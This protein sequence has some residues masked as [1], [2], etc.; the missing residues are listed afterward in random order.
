MTEVEIAPQRNRGWGRLLVVTAALFVGLAGFTTAYAL[1]GNSDDDHVPDPSEGAV[2]Y[3][4]D[5]NPETYCAP[6]IGEDLQVLDRGTGA[7]VSG[8]KG[9]LCK[10][11]LSQV[12]PAYKKANL[13]PVF[14]FRNGAVG[15]EYHERRTETPSAGEVEQSLRDAGID[16]ESVPP[17]VLTS[18]IQTMDP[19]PLT[20]EEAAQRLEA[21]R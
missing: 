10:Q 9:E 17:E 15:V 6:F 7:I 12:D 1:A 21:A 20:P 14:V 3:P 11:A 16:P 18:E 4:S 8:S 13:V 5:P 19:N 2:E